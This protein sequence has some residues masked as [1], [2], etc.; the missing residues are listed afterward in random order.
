MISF[1]FNASKIMQNSDHFSVFRLLWQAQGINVFLIPKLR[2]MWNSCPKQKRK[3]LCRKRT[4]CNLQLKQPKIPCYHKLCCREETSDF[5]LAW[6]I[7][8]RT[9]EQNKQLCKDI[10]HVLHCSLVKQLASEFLVFWPDSSF[11]SID[12]QPP[13]PKLTLGRSL[14]SQALV[15]KG[16]DIDRVSAV[17]LPLP[18]CGDQL[19]TAVWLHSAHTDNPGVTCQCTISSCC[20]P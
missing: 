14:I 20:S 10:L 13:N 5:I 19:C 8:R 16:T 18:P 9:F 6:D 7:S 15:A 11:K 2:Q 3:I 12:L 4:I 1:H 17:R